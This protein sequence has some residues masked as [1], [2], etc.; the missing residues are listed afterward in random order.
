MKIRYYYLAGFA[1][2]VNDYGKTFRLTDS[3]FSDFIL[4]KKSKM[5]V[6]GQHFNY[7]YTEYQ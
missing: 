5:R 6:V 7:K 3:E 4:N 1:E 2:Y